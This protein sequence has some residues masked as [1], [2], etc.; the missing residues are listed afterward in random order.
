MPVCIMDV[1]E[2][3]KWDKKESGMVMSAF[4]W[5]YMTTQILGG[6]LSDRVGG[7]RVLLA[8]SVLWS[9][10]TFCTPL[11][12]HLSTY[13]PFPILL[14]VVFRVLLGISQGVHFPSATSLVSRKVHN[15]ERSL[16]VSLI[17]T[18]ANC[19]TLLSG[20]MGSFL[21]ERFGWQKPF[22]VIGCCGLLWAIVMY[23][24]LI[25]KQHSDSPL[26]R[27]KATDLNSNINASTP[28]PW[29][30]LFSRSSFWALLVANYCYNNGFYIL[31]SW[32]PTFFHENFPDAKKQAATQV[33]LTPSCKTITML[34]GKI[35]SVWC[36]TLGICGALA[37]LVHSHANSPGLD[38][39]QDAETLLAANEGLRS[40]MTK[41]QEEMDVVKMR[42]QSMEDLMMKCLSKLG[43]GVEHS[44]LKPHHRDQRERHTDP[45]QGLKSPPNPPQPGAYPSQRLQSPRSDD[46]G[47]LEVVVNGLSQQVV[48]LSAN[49]QALK[50]FER[51]IQASK[52]ST[53]V[54]WGSHACRGSSQTVYAGVV[55]GSHHTHSG[56]AADFLCLTLEPRF[57][58]V[59]AG[60]TYTLLYGGE[61]ETNDSHQDMDPDCAVCHTSH[62]STIMVPGTDRCA[63]GWT[64]QYSGYLM[65]G[66]YGHQGASQFVCVDALLESRAGSKDNYNGHLLYYT[67]TACGSLPC[68]P[69]VNNKV[70]TCAVC[71]K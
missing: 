62:S 14:I 26:L 56:A 2:E 25:C 10:V 27:T 7:E 8:A 29:L 47:P 30:K 44:G 6:Y 48:Q 11:I 61:Y 64:L 68:L 21:T 37:V 71:S 54:H 60:R 69:Y 63:S 52:G 36:F 45:P 58:N 33:V 19:G 9:T 13:T 70:V 22:Y 39:P 38:R 65:A 24:C 16:T 43:S 51:D 41:L 59:V 28:V 3:M 17:A 67:R 34:F 49:I 1:A 66:Y 5:G 18:G 23:R 46:R 12:I 35:S 50:T 20:S 4:F 57:K 55:G 40:K 32:L 15:D 31:L 53:F 42:Q